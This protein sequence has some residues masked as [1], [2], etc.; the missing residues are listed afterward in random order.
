MQT[1][2]QLLATNMLQ[3]ACKGSG[4]TVYCASVEEHV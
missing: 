1:V 4:A 2:K 3:C